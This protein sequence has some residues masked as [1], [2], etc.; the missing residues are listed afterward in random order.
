MISALRLFCFFGGLK[1]VSGISNKGGIERKRIESEC[2]ESLSRPGGS[3][4]KS[5]TTS[6]Y[7]LNDNIKN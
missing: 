1:K 5:A 2:G 4:C 7:Y 3:E 6:A